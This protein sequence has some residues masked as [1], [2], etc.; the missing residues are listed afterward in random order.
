MAEPPGASPHRAGAITAGT[1]P[2][3][4]ATRTSTSGTTSTTAPSSAGS[5]TTVAAQAVSMA[6]RRRPGRPSMTSD[7]AGPISGGPTRS[8]PPAPSPGMAGEAP[9]GSNRCA[10]PRVS[11]A[12]IT[13][14]PAP[15]N[16]V[17]PAIGRITRHR[18]IGPPRPVAASTRAQ[19][20]AAAPSAAETGA[21]T[22]T[23]ATAA[24]AACVPPSRAA[25]G[26]RPVCAESAVGPDVGK[27]AGDEHRSNV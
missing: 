23:L 21:S 22:A 1:G 11:R 9:R 8:A 3:S 10:V 19:A 13:T 15:A 4:T 2:Y 12:S 6:G 18:S 16:S 7:M 14:G 24:S 26:R 20:S 5:P 17:P 25:S 27:G